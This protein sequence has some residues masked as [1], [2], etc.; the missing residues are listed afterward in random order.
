MPRRPNNPLRYP[1]AKGK[2]VDYV[3]VVLEENLLAGCTIHEPFGGSAAVSLDLLSRGFATKAIIVERDP[4]VFS[5]WR[6]VFEDADRL[7]QDIEELAVNMGTWHALD[8]L[9]MIDRPTQSILPSLALA[10]LFY[11]RTNYSG[12][13]GAGPIGGQ[14]Q[15]SDYKIDCRF[16]KAAVVASIRWYSE[17]KGRVEVVFDDA[18]MYLRRNQ[19]S[20]ES[21]FHF[22]YLDPPYY[23]H[24]KKYYRYH[25]GHGQHAE[26][27]RFLVRRKFPW[28]LSYDDHPVIREMYGKLDRYVIYMDYSARTSRRAKELLVSNLVIPPQVAVAAERVPAL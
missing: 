1:G 5:F 7:C 23:G 4:L 10:G 18:M 25:Y 28:L 6:M 27:A 3:A 9:R 20:L 15:T 2:L 12:I 21:G 14:S 13:V 17:L 22:V 26:L 11:N 16:N 19:E 24:G 8:H